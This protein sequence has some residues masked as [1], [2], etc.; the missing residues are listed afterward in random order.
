MKKSSVQKFQNAMQLYNATALS[1]KEH[2]DTYEW[3]M[4]DK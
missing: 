2:S 1:N 3:H 4:N